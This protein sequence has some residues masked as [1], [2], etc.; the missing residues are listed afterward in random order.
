ML[1]MSCQFGFESVSGSGNV[2]KENRNIGDFTSVEAAG[3]MDV[4]IKTGSGYKVEVE[5]DDNLMQY[6]ITRKEGNNL[7]IKLKNNLNIR[8]DN[9]IHVH[10]EMPALKAVIVSG[11]GSVK[12]ID[13]LSDPEQMKL[14]I[15]GSGNLIMDVKSPRVEVSV[16][17]SGKATVKGETRD[18]DLDIAGSGDFDGNDLKSEKVDISISGSGNAKVF[19]S[20]DLKVSVAGSGDVIYRGNPK[21]SQSIAGSGSVKQAQ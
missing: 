6:I 3:P 11:S 17:G 5:A 10:L 8:N 21:I 16:A 13:Q 19:A 9:G 14:K 20:V 15:A 12:S 18:L 7:V 2:I 4:D 1:I